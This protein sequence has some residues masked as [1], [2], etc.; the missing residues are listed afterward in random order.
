MTEQKATADD[1]IGQVLYQT[2]C[3]CVCV[4]HRLDYV[5]IYVDLVLK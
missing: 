5:F 1:T 4:W 2:V 3:V